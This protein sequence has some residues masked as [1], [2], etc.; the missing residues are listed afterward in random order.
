VIL[1]ELT[2]GLDPRARRRM[3]ATVERLRDEGATILLVS[4]AMEEV[5]RLCDR[6]ALL[7]AGRIV[8]QDTP[9]GLVAKTGAQDLDEAFVQL[10]GKYL[11]EEA[12]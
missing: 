7:D 6:I 10:T 4:H 11:E 12:A 8:A 3:W 1:D 5:E 9:A 2:T